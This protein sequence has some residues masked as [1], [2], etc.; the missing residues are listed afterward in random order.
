LTGNEK[1]IKLLDFPK[2]IC[3]SF[4]AKIFFLFTTFFIVLY[5]AFTVFF[6]YSQ[7]KIFRQNLVHEG[8]E[9][10]NLLAYSSR[11]GVFA[12]NRDLLKTPVMSIMQ[13]EAVKSI[14]VFT[15]DGKELETRFR[16]DRETAG[17]YTELDTT[18]QKKIIDM[19][20]KSKSAFNFERGNVMEFWAPVISGADIYGEEALFFDKISSFKK[21]TVIGFVRIVFTTE[22]LNKNLNDILLRSILISV[23]FMIPGWIII[24]F[25]ARKITRPLN[26]L[27]EGVAA[28]GSGGTVEEVTVETKDEIGNL[29]SAFNNMVESLRRKDIEKKEIEDQLRHAQKMEAIGALAGGIAHDFNNTLSAIIGYAHLLQQ[30][31]NK[32]G[33]VNK[34]IDHL[35]STSRRAVGFTQGL[36]T[37]SRKEVANPRLVELNK[38]VGSLKEILTRLLGEDIDFTVELAEK[39]LV[40]MADKG[41]IEHVL[42]NLATNARDAMPDGGC[43]T[44]TVKHAEADRKIS[45]SSGRERQ[46]DY[47]LIS[48]ADTGKGMNEQTKEK[49]YDPFFTTKETGKGTGLGLSMVYGIIKQHNGRIDVSSEAGKGTTF[50][51]YLPLSSSVIED[52]KS[53]TLLEP[54]GGTETILVAEDDEDLRRF[55][56]LMLEQYGYKVIEAENGEDAIGKFIENKDKVK[57]LLFDMIMPKKNGKGAFEEIKKIRA[58]IKVIFMSGYAPEDM[59]DIDSL[60]EETAFIPKPLLSEK[61]AQKVREALDK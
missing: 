3:K 4:G 47:A 36:L 49:I 15:V 2:Y 30:E 17:G 55:T 31:I 8:K 57:L 23:L 44:I 37:F 10:V 21:D 20:K 9:F 28:V 43:L 29:A 40:I 11:L 24:Y 45:I 16:P 1:N 58:D 12:E 51:I 52:E 50:K 32:E 53:E 48:F 18:G 14:Q 38:I 56:T 35:L 6:V 26:R 34:Y 27:T 54:G 61:L 60:V 13:L 41:Q 33:Y 25:I 19:L 42:M 22:L 39:E 46:G 5:C 7:C 59:Q